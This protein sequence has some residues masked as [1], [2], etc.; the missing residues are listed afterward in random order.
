[1]VN[2]RKIYY[3]IIVDGKCFRAGGKFGWHKIIEIYFSLKQR[4]STAREMEKSTKL[5]RNIKKVNFQEIKEKN[6]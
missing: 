1:M 3:G 6:G 5:Y 2:K 4:E